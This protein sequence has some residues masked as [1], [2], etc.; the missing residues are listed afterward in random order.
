MKP[1]HDLRPF[2]DLLQHMALG[3]IEWSEDLGVDGAIS[4]TVY[5]E[6]KDVGILVGK[7]GR[8]FG[9]MALLLKSVGVELRDYVK[10]RGTQH[11]WKPTGKWQDAQMLGLM[12]R[13]LAVVL[14][15]AIARSELVGNSV[16][17]RVRYVGDSGITMLAEVR[18]HLTTLWEAVGKKHGWS[19]G[20]VFEWYEREE[21][22][23]QPAF[24]D[25]RFAKEV[26]HGR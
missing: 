1:K 5:A 15:G 9:A 12:N 18:R 8:R 11:A 16:T 20:V 22:G 6:D 10:V 14:P 3:P 17:Y 19:V 25:G 7:G 21:S 4:V 23:Q 2:R 13:L 26:E 24:S